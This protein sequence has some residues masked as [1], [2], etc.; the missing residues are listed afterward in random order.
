[1]HSTE[2]C[3]N[4]CLSLKYISVNTLTKAVSVYD[5]VDAV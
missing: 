3:S 5:A 4:N 1:M 2:K